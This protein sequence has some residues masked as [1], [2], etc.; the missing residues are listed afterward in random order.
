[1]TLLRHILPKTVLSR[2]FFPP[3]KELLEVIS[4]SSLP[5]GSSL[6]PYAVSVG[7]RLTVNHVDY[8]GSLP[9]ISSIPDQLSYIGLSSPLA[10]SEDSDPPSGQPLQRLP[11]PEIR[12]RPR[13]ITSRSLFNPFFGYPV[14][15]LPKSSDNV[16]GYFNGYNVP[17]LQHGR[18][19]K[20]DL[21]R[22]LLRL[23]WERW[24]SEIKTAAWIVAI[25]AA[26]W[27]RRSPILRQRWSALLELARKR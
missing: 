25:V 2:V 3:K 16:D 10:P 24:R 27:M 7:G 8:G 11:Q 18:R 14:V 5:D 21:A 20:R 19:R 4:P 13:H 22:T 15:P 23:W 12:R 26:L 9:P 1:L 17:N 6:A